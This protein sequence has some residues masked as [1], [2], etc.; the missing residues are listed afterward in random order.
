M[1]WGAFMLQFVFGFITVWGLIPTPQAWACGKVR[2]ADFNR[3]VEQPRIL[4]ESQDNLAQ[5]TFPPDGGKPV[6][7]FSDVSRAD[8]ITACPLE[9]LPPDLDL[10]MSQLV[11]KIRG[12]VS[13]IKATRTANCAQLQDRFQ[14]SQGQIS[15]AL[16]FQFMAGG[17]I[18]PDSNQDKIN[19]Q[20][21]QAGAVNLLIL[22]ASDMIHQECISSIDDRIVIQKLIGQVITLSG[23]FAGGWQG[24]LTATGGQL[25]GNLPLFKDEVENALKVF[26]KYDEVNER[27]SFL[28]L[29]RQMQKTSCFLF[30]DESNFIING[31]DLTFKTGPSSTTLDSIKKIRTDLPNQ[32]NDLK[33][34]K[35]LQDKSDDYLSHIEKT[36]NLSHAYLES[37]HY[38]RKWCND[39]SLFGL[40]EKDLF[41]ASIYANIRSLQQTCNQLNQFEWTSRT[42]SEVVT[43]LV[44]SYWNISTL[45][46]YYLS[47]LKDQKSNLGKIAST[48][49]SFLYF[50]GLK[51]SAD[52]YRDSTSGNQKRLNYKNLTE[53]L[54]DTLAKASFRSIM[55]QNY[56]TMVEKHHFGKNIL[57]D[58]KVRQRALTAMIDLCRTLDPTLTCLYFDNPQ[59]NSLYKEW[60]SNC[61]G[62][63]SLLCRDALKDQKLEAL[64]DRPHYRAY[65]HSL[66]GIDHL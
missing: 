20:T 45:R 27:G 7:H 63:K 46:H 41:L 33:I 4:A 60:N 38:L 52:E 32:L 66:C 26:Q 30:T 54:G 47:I 50:E 13:N 53:K 18:T 56:S 65:F 24:I 35:H 3:I 43:T 48:W 12:S 34:L 6:I 21:R 22:T 17:S 55:K 9:S 58:D 11:T 59:E 42:E 15:E 37:F 31:L 23:L 44:D 1:S 16:K 5:I 64:L 62:P 57:H 28:C 61:V 40:M 14:N 19:A 39:H 49:E 10:A 36:Q 25:L 29:F 2:M 51:S 8:P